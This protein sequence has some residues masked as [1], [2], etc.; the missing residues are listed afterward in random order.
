MNKYQYDYLIVGSGLSG[1]IF[2]HEA[3][4]RGKKCL[5][6]E[7]RE[8]TGGNIRCEN[9][10]DINVHIYGA[11]IFHTD[12]V[13]I[14]EYI[15]RFATFNNFINSPLANY[16]GRLFNL[17]FNMNTFYQLWGTLT[18]A[19]AY[20]RLESQRK[21][22][23]L[24]HSPKNLE[25]QALMLCGKD[26]YEILI[27]GYTEKQWGCSAQ[28]LP[29][30][31][32]RRIPSRFT[33]DNNYFTD[34]YQGIPIGGYNPIINKLLEGIEVVT[35]C[36]F[37]QERYHFENIAPKIIY[38]G[39]IDEF[40]HYQLGALEYRSLQ[41]DTQTKNTDN[42]QGNAV[43][44]Y[45]AK[46]IPYTRIIEHKHFEFGN[47]PHTVITYEYPATFQKGSEPY[48]PVNNLHNSVLYQR[49]QELARSCPHVIFCG[50]LAEYKYY[51]MDDTVKSALICAEHE[52]K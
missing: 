38:T 19:E 3:H 51:D 24:S 12:D 20:E 48:Y 43:I 22:F 9:M 41:F 18:P 34:R 21:A 35:N 52:F 29:A 44:N 17:P 2:A 45:T 47:Q 46:E 5:V 31:I 28:E 36:N 8:K 23:S 4:L 32:I 37:N 50:R 26:I 7:K 16:K 11:H 33:F 40:F 1:A 25:E 14:W 42:F 27:K 6:I 30:E 49:Y 13:N 10:E 15:N 39:C